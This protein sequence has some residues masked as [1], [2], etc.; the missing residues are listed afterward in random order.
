MKTAC[1]F[2]HPSVGILTVGFCV[3]LE[4]Q[5]K[6]ILAARILILALLSTAVILSCKPSAYDSLINGYGDRLVDIEAWTVSRQT[7]E[8]ES[9]QQRI[10]ALTSAMESLGLPTPSQ[11]LRVLYASGR[12]IGYR[13]WAADTEGNVW[14]AS[15]TVHFTESSFSTAVAELK[16]AASVFAIEELYHLR[17]WIEGPSPLIERAVSW[18]DATLAVWLV[19]E[20]I[21][22]IQSKRDDA[23]PELESYWSH[24]AAEEIMIAL[25]GRG[26]LELE[27]FRLRIRD[28]ITW[29]ALATD[30]RT[31]IQA[32][33]ARY[34][35]GDRGTYLTERKRFY[36]AWLS[37]Y[38]ANYE[39]R[40][41]TNEFR[42]FGEPQLTDLELSI[43]DLTKA[44]WGQYESQWNASDGGFGR[45]TA[46]VF[47]EGLVD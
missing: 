3:T 29:A 34:D 46:T 42:D 30:L 15:P 17:P 24:K 44:N 37:N 23:S 38:R 9:L 5:M 28:E 40:F 45:F 26:S 36:T 21:G 12:G 13:I 31:Q 27:Q 11:P 7:A 39:N 22:G 6:L 18:G 10:F 14:S 33:S 47:P 8:A 2:F 25:K 32:L 19:T 43:L 20:G 41:L 4:K 1:H 35:T 16:S